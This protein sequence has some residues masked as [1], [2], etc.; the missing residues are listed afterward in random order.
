MVAPDLEADRPKS[1]KE[2]GAFFTPAAIAEHLTTWALGSLKTGSVLDPTCGDGAFLSA[3]ES[4][5]TGLRGS[6]SGFEYWGI[7]IDRESLAHAQKRLDGSGAET[8]FVLKDFFNVEPS[9]DVPLVDAIIGNP[10][11]IRFHDHRGASRVRSQEVALLGGV[12]LNGLA[13]SWAAALVHSS[14]FL[15]STGRL[16]MVLPAEL[17]TVSYAAPVRNWLRD[18]FSSVNIVLFDKLQFADAQADVVLLLA[19]GTGGCHAFSLWPVATAEDLERIKPYTQVNV[20]VGT[21]VKWSDF[22]LGT[23]SRQ[24]KAEILSRGYVPLAEYFEVKLGN[25]TGANA[26]FTLTEDERVFHELVPGRD[27][28]RLVPSGRRIRSATLSAR[29]WEELR[30][31]GE[32]VWL[33]APSGKTPSSSALAYIDLGRSMKV[34]R[35][36]KC[37]TRTP[38]W[39]VPVGGAPDLLFSYMSN[40]APRA[41]VNSVKA[42]Q[43]NSM[44][45]LFVR[46]ATIRREL[47]AL[48][49]VM[50]LNSGTLLSAELNGRSYGGGILKLELGETN[51]L[52]MPSLRLM[53]DAWELLVSSGLGGSLTRGSVALDEHVGA[54]DQAL[55]EASSEIDERMMS[56]LN[57]GWKDQRRRRTSKA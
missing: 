40:Q 6:S 52:P 45:G 39:R 13:S 51:S 31:G 8:H 56:A 15:K 22:L 46:D 42:V 44:H 3:A 43:L 41:T 49:A 26:F 9:D 25:V 30:E 35:G 12:E 24:A 18:R 53:R 2:R 23:D 36:Y 57:R 21:D 14:R 34:D 5:L 47:S 7:D 37:R 50:L 11:F 54:V 20:N 29:R 55:V 32:R 28:R 48:A 27:V 38:W 16:A 17:L 4:V 19:E 1:R 33:F 10:P